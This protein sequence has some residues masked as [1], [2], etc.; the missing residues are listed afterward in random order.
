M[1]KKRSYQPIL[2]V[3]TILFLI[4]ASF[5]T[6]Y[7]GFYKQTIYG[8][9]S[10][11]KVGDIIKFHATAQVGSRAYITCYAEPDLVTGNP[12][13]QLCARVSLGKKELKDGCNGLPCNL[14]DQWSYTP[15]EAKNTMGLDVK[16]TCSG[17][18]APPNDKLTF[19]VKEATTPCNQAGGYFIVVGVDSCKS[20]Y[21][22]SSEPIAGLQCCLPQD[23]PDF[24]IQPIPSTEKICTDSDGNDITKFGSVHYY[25]STYQYNYYKEDICVNDAT[26]TE[27][28]CDS[29]RKIGVSNNKQCPSETK[30]SGGACLTTPTSGGSY[31]G[32]EPIIDCKTGDKGSFCRDNKR[33]FLTTSIKFDE[34]GIRRC[35]DEERLFEICSDD[36]T[37][38]KDAGCV[39][40][41][42]EGAIRNK[43]C[44]DL[45]FV[46]YQQF[47][48][49]QWK[50]VT[51]LCVGDQFCNPETLQCE[52][53]EDAPKVK[54]NETEKD[55]EKAKEFDFEEFFK[56]YGIVIGITAF[57]LVV[58]I[59]FI[60]AMMRR[61]K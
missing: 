52:L 55:K 49:G 59:I 2:I 58:G 21:T 1:S 28:T 8:V 10:E 32:G 5:L 33:Y 44:K 23:A 39:P 30:C 60:V 46:G 24:T 14:Y 35:V 31:G 27:W 45:E 12:D 25:S 13:C 61:K 26:I 16:Y 48:G 3:I 54:T 11:V 20:G 57:L 9:P 38:N 22:A 42:E 43:K 4:L 6:Y 40:D 47:I 36:E 53:K 51:E 37:C 17:V 18:T 29:E 15:K 41:V 56:T 50:D 7:F 34:S 19:S